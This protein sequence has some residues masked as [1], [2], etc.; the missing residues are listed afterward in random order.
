MFDVL[1]VVGCNPIALCHTSQASFWFE[2][3]WPW[4]CQ[5]HRI[6]ASYMVH[7]TSHVTSPHVVSDVHEGYEG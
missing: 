4:Q 6:A 1:A 7:V 5:L 2:S 3:C